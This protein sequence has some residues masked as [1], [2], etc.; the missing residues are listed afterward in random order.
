M[1]WSCTFQLGGS[2]LMSTIRKWRIFLSFSAAVKRCFLFRWWALPH[3]WAVPP[4]CGCQKIKKYQK[5]W[6][7]CFLHSKRPNCNKFNESK[8][9]DFFFYHKKSRVMSA[10]FVETRNE[11]EKKAKTKEKANGCDN[12]GKTETSR[13]C[14]YEVR[15]Q[16]AVPLN[17]C[18]CSLTPACTFCPTGPTASSLPGLN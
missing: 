15:Y 1:S 2:C 5:T 6:L 16:R 14:N 17:Y 3:Y 4:Q 10:R 7:R 13:G 11:G 18:P 12:K 8:S 9:W